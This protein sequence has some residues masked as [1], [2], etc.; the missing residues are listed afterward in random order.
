MKSEKWKVKSGKEKDKNG[1]TI[2]YILNYGGFEIAILL[3]LVY[4]VWY[5]YLGQVNSTWEHVDYVI[6]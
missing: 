6:L 2:V 1:E 3:E 5:N 4:S